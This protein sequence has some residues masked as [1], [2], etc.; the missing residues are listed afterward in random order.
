MSRVTRG[1]RRSLTHRGESAE[2]L[3]VGLGNPGSK[4]SGTRHNLGREVVDEVVQ[5]KDLALKAGKDQALV[6][7][8]RHDQKLVVFAIP[9]TYMNDSGIAVAKLVRRYRLEEIKKLLIVHDELDLDVGTI[10]LKES[11]GMA[12]HNGLRSVSQHIKTHD[13]C[14]IRIG[15]RGPF[16]AQK[17]AQHVLSRPGKKERQE[18]DLSIMNA[19]DSIDIILNEG[20]ESAMRTFNKK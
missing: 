3:V 14:R 18:L 20:F 4:F 11:G 2:L 6:A 5:R 7:E 15:I 16:E 13:F 9:M 17:G 1:A 12:G 19:A 8:G 10:R